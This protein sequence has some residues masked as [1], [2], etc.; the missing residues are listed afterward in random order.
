MARKWWG[1]RAAAKLS[2]LVK[3]GRGAMDTPGRRVLGIVETVFIDHAFFRFVYANHHH[4][5]GA[6]WRSSQPSPA[7]VRKAANAGIR[8]ILN[9]RGRRDCASYVLEAEACRR[10]GITLIDFPVNSRSAPSRET[11]RAA[12]ELFRTM[13]YPAL[14]HCKSGAD[15]A[16][17]MAALYLLV[18]ENRPVA[19]A[20]QQLSWRFGHFRQART[21]VLDHVFDL[22]QAAAAGSPITFAA[23]VDTAYDPEAAQASF[24]SRAWADKVIDGVLERE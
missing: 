18:H 8:T 3:R 13:E 19:E 17:F 1:R 7:Q 5:G 2:D 4:V 10:H 24:R 14:L 11:I 9:L 15:R 6:L 16:G 20:K 12:T 21:G 22:Y 23:W